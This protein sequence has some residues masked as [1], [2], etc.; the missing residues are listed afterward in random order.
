MRIG[1][2]YDVHRLVPGRP[3]ILGG[4]EIPH[5]L[6]LFGYSD[7]DV[8]LHAVC[9]ALLGA[10]GL[11]DLGEHFPDTDPAYKGIPSLALLE[12]TGNKLRALG[13]CVGNLD[14]TLVA[15]KPKISSYKKQMAENIARALGIESGRVN[16]K[17]TTTEGLGITGREEGMAA[18][19]V[20][21]IEKTAGAGQTQ[22]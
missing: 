8:L 3:L 20:A 6:G 19:C 13:F 5:H 16:V 7:A 15:E 2:G 1:Y 18:T 17:A 14:A 12:E 10:A 21:L 4:V 9:D 11:G 22:G